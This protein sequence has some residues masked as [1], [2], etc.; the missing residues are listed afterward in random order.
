MIGLSIIVALI[1]VGVS[2]A[3]YVSSGASQLD[4][5]R[6]GYRAVSDQVVTNDSDFGNYS[7]TGT[8]DQSAIDQFK[9]LYDKQSAKAQAV[10]AFGGDPLSPDALE[11]SAPTASN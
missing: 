7:A 9:T 1:L 2:M 10:D 6:P 8:L 4:L 5:S 3:L 11:L